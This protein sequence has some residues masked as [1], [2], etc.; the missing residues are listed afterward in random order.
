MQYS[1]WTEH[2]IAVDSPDHVTAEHSGA[3]NDNSRNPNFNEKLRTLFGRDISLLDLGCAGGGFVHSLIKDGHFAIG[4]EGS[5]YCKTRKKFEWE[6]LDGT[7]LFTADITKPFQVIG[8]DGQTNHNVKFDVVTCWEVM[9]HITVQ[10]LPKLVKNV[11]EHLEPAGI[12]VMSV[13]EQRDGYFH[14]TIE[15]RRWWLRF[16]EQHGLV[17]DEAAYNLFHPDWV[18]GPIQTPWAICAGQSFHLVMRRA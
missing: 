10:D 9:E 11:L 15:T 6:H 13:S 14:R 12:W 18:R 4:V 1:L 17:F 8:T 2:P 5:D 16:F 3:G 7:R